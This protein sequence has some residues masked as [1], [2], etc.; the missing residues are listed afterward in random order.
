MNVELIVED[1]DSSLAPEDLE[2]VHHLILMMEVEKRIGETCFVGMVSLASTLDEFGQEGWD[3]L[4]K[5]FSD[6]TYARW[7]RDMF[8][9]MFAEEVQSS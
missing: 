6:P 5:E 4:E 8:E 2:K 1:A 9:T 7:L 3:L